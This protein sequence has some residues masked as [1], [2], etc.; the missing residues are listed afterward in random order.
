MSLLDTPGFG[1]TRDHIQKHAEVAFGLSA[2]Y[3]YLL[4]L[5][6]IAGEASQSFFEDL[7]A[8]DSSK[9]TNKTHAIT[10]FLIMGYSYN[11]CAYM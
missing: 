10:F 6:E 3:I 4:P 9:F 1:E 2:A 11:T 8:H 7:Q 5:E